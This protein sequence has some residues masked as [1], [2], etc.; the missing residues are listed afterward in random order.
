MPHVII[1]DDNEGFLDLLSTMCLRAGWTVETCTNGR[2]L[3]EAA[4]SGTNAA[5]LLIDINMPIV[6]GIEV[7]DRLKDLPRPVRLRFMTGGDSAPMIAAGLI[8]SARELSVGRN[9]FKP[10]AKAKFM[11]LLEEEADLLASMSAE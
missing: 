2:D 1:A 3:I 7:V 5:L 11:T 9:I 8:A 4:T 6:D 10:I